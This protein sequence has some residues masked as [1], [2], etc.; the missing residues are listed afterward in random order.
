MLVVA[1]NDSTRTVVNVV[2]CDGEDRSSGP[3]AVRG[4]HARVSDSPV[5]HAIIVAAGCADGGACWCCSVW[6]KNVRM[7]VN[8]DIRPVP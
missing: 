7:G 3:T 2:V 6:I 1:S 5:E 8:R 4:S